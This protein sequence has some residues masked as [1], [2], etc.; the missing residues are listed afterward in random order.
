MSGFRMLN[1]FSITAYVKDFKL[2]NLSLL[3]AEFSVLMLLFIFSSGSLKCARSY[4]LYILHLSSTKCSLVLILNDDK[5]HF[6]ATLPEL[7]LSEHPKEQ[8]ITPRNFEEEDLTRNT[9][10]LRFGV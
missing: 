8:A 6:G 7:L 1:M 5:L 9:K 10:D 2:E 3:P 4:S